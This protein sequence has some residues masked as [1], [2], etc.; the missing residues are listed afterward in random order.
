[1]LSVCVVSDSPV[2]T[3]SIEETTGVT[4]AKA[5]TAILLE[6]ATVAARDHEGR[7]E[8]TQP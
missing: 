1:M 2:K 6:E 8:I 4:T 5:P 7:D 3:Y